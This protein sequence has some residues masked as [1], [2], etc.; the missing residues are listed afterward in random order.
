MHSPGLRRVA[1]EAP[2]GVGKGLPAVPAPF[3]AVFEFTERRG[4]FV[5]VVRESYLMR[6]TIEVEDFGFQGLR[7]TGAH[8]ARS[9]RIGFNRRARLPLDPGNQWDPEHEPRGPRAPARGLCAAWARHHE[10]LG[11]EQPSP[12]GPS[13]FQAE[14]TPEYVTVH[15]HGRAQPARVG[16]G[17]QLA[18]FGLSSRNSG[19]RQSNAKSAG[20]D[21]SAPRTYLFRIYFLFEASDRRI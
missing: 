10:R 16:A 14:E 12:G 3:S 18:D 7:D 5:Y 2:Q 15:G 6:S 8:R 13:R 11:A 20:F 9:T 1:H 19:C 4:S 17:V 21:N